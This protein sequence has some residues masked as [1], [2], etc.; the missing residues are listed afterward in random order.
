MMIF[1]IMTM[2][3]LI[4]IPLMYHLFEKKGLKILFLLFYMLAYIFTLKNIKILN[5]DFSLMIIPYVSLLSILYI[6]NQKISA[7]DIKKNLHINI[8]FMLTIIILLII[9]FLYNPSVTDLTTANLNNL[10]ESN[11]VSLILF[12]IVTVISLYGTY[13]LYNFMK[14]SGNILFINISLTT[15][16]IGIIDCILFAILANIGNF[17]IVSSVKLGLGNYLMKII[18]SLVFIPII[19]YVVNRKKG[20]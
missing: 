16:L 20:I 8:L 18:L 11:I 4:S 15:I 10:V 19:S 3:C 2:L 9:L 12:P 7:K 6:A 13:K 17:N 14:K 5:I 1:V